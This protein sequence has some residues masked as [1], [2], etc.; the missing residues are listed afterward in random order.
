MMRAI[1]RR[2]LLTPLE[3]F[4]LAVAA[5]GHDADHPGV[6]NAFLIATNE[7]LAVLYNDTAVL[8]RGMG[9][10]GCPARLP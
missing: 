5:L 9:G 4:A 7:P 1:E 8:V 6:T 3:M 10:G 2:G